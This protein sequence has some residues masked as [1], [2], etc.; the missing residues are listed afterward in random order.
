MS[1]LERLADLDRDLEAAL[2]PELLGR[3]ALFDE[4]EIHTDPYQRRCMALAD[5]QA[6]HVAELRDQGT[7]WKAEMEAMSF[8]IANPERPLLPSNLPYRACVYR[9][10]GQQDGA[11]VVISG[12]RFTTIEIAP[13]GDVIEMPYDVPVIVNGKPRVG[14]GSLDI[15]VM[16]RLVTELEAQRQELRLGHDLAAVLQPRRPRKPRAENPGQ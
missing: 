9:L 6:R 13:T 5:L 4:E 11:P 10:N 16:D 14:F 12:V 7:L 15:D 8:S 1:D 2:P 3:L